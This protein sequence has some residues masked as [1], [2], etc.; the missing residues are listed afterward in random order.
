MDSSASRTFDFVLI[1]SGSMAV[2][3][4][5]VT[6]D[7]PCLSCGALH[8]GMAWV[9]VAKHE[10]WACC[11]ALLRVAA[12]QLMVGWCDSALGW[13]AVDADGRHLRGRKEDKEA[14]VLCAYQSPL[15]GDWKPK[16]TTTGTLPS[17][18]CHFPLI[19]QFVS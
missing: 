14:L 17:K 8:A 1:N 13:S 16:K 3:V 15:R 5:R 9:C 12:T 18:L 10:S 19:A 11:I 6:T 7:N 2:A 4:D